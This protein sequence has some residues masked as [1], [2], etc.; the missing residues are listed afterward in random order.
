MKDLKQL[1]FEDT[2]IVLNRH[3]LGKLVDLTAEEMIQILYTEPK[4]FGHYIERFNRY[5]VILHFK[6]GNNFNN[7]VF[8]TVK[9]FV[10]LKDYLKS[11][12][13]NPFRY[14]SYARDGMWLGYKSITIE[15]YLTGHI[16]ISN[17]NNHSWSK[18]K[19]NVDHETQTISINY[20]HWM[21]D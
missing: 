8:E 4:N 7:E 11:N 14:Y 12:N 13:D 19:F 20:T 15:E 18:Y 21:V 1:I 3:L 6:S 10:S 17:S 5:K 9:E 16:E 2:S